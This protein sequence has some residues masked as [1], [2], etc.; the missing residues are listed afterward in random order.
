[1][2]INIFKYKRKFNMCHVCDIKTDYF[3][4]FSKYISKLIYANFKIKY[5]NGIVN[6]HP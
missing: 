2:Q 3:K 6:D 5:C 1:M 4:N